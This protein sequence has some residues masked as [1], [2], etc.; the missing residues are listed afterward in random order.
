MEKDGY[1]A[2]AMNLA[3]SAFKFFSKNVLKKDGISRLR[4]P[5]QDRTLPPVLSKQEIKKILDT[6]ENPKH[7]LLLM[8]VY[9]S[10]LRVS[11]AVALKREHIDFHRKTVFV[12]GGKGRKD[13]CT[14]LSEKA[15]PFIKEYFKEFGIKTW[16]FPGYP[17]NRHLTIRTAQRVYDKSAQKAGIIKDT[18]IHGLRHT[19]ATHLLES[20]TEIRYIQTLLGH[21][22]VRTTERYARVAIHNVLNVK[23]PP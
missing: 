15:V 14:V 9:S 22:S 10:G 23:S 21:S 12:K 16:V 2:S 6:E 13:R 8:I 3:F 11:E 19:F 7:R 20:G 5:R 17:S 1:S 18:S 4:R